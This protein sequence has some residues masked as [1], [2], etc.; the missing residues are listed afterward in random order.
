[1]PLDDALT[2]EVIDDPEEYLLRQLRINRK[3]MLEAP[4]RSV[5][6]DNAFQRVLHFCRE[7]LIARIETVED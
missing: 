1:M 5:E 2:T 6:R 4:V 7:I 3:I